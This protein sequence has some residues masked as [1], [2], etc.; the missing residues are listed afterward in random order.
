MQLTSS[1]ERTDQRQHQHN[2]ATLGITVS[3]FHSV[4]VE[5]QKENLAKNPAI[6]NR[7]FMIYFEQLCITGI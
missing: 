1:Y 4:S 2:E 3:V 5:I 7:I 6:E